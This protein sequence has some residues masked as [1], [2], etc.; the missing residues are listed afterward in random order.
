M[1]EWGLLGAAMLATGFIGRRK[2]KNT[3]QAYTGPVYCIDWG[4]SPR[5]QRL[6]RADDP[7]DALGLRRADAEDLLLRFDE[8]EEARVRE[9]AES[10]KAE[11]APA[12]T[13]QA[14][15]ININNNGGTE[16]VAPTPPDMA[17]VYFEKDEP[18]T[19]EDFAGQP[20]VVTSFERA[21]RALPPEKC[22]LDPQLFLGPPGMGKTLFAKIVTNELRFRNMELGFPEP[23][24]IE[25][26]P[27]D[28]ADVSEL[29]AVIRRAMLTRGSVLFIDEIHE[30]TDKHATK[31]YM[32]LNEKRY[33]FHNESA[34]TLLPDITILGA[35]TDAGMMKP[36]MLR[37]FQPWNFLPASKSELMGYIERRAFPIATE[38]AELI[39]D[40]TYFSGAP[41]EG[42]QLR[43]QAEIFARARRAPQITEADVQ[44]VFEVQGV[45]DLGLRTVDRRILHAMFKCPRHRNLP[46]GQGVEFVCYG[47]S[48]AV[49]CQLAGVDRAQY[50]EAIKPR[51]MAR[52]L[53]EVKFGYGQT[54][55][56]KGV[57][58]VAKFAGE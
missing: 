33:K 2:S 40:R 49:V 28:I 15:T 44:E 13:P 7:H 12:Q 10:L 14:I 43:K 30:F 6:I 25:V 3:I 34:P 46:R 26:F 36:A 4:L 32:L 11:Q 8:E 53:I 42:L 56:T 22:A 9:L 17:P 41:W 45:D 29:D 38:A 21:I 39:V 57:E 23:D 37:R 27:A 55:T 47:Q 18:T 16:E 48:E 20:H 54:L 58:H 1:I 35:T 51:L 24:F 50:S 19:F 52:G 31:M 5:V